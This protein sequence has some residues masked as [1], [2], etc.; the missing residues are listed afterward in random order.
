MEGK[1]EGRIFVG[2]LSWQTDEAKLEDAFGRF[3]KVVGAQVLPR[4]SPLAPYAPGCFARS[5]RL[6]SLAL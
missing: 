5:V 3:G 1:E 2:G 4:P 6:V